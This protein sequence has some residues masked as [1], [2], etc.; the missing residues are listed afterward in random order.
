MLEGRN[1]F[2]AT[3]RQMRD[4]AHK[5]LAEG[6]E[7]IT[8]GFA[9]A[10]TGDLRRYNH[11]TK[12]EVAAVFVASDGAPPGYRDLVMW[13]RSDTAPVHRVDIENEHLD[14]CTCTLFCFLMVTL[15]G[16]R[17]SDTP[18]RLSRRNSK[19]SSTLA[20]RRCSSTLTS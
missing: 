9:A 7:D 5:Y 3:F 16:T 11:P 19:S 15:D 6:R 10:T 8:L 12:E 2:V 20:C 18:A 14:P 4:V 13:P 1:P 17:I